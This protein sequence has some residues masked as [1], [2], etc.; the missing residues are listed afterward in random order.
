MNHLQRTPIVNSLGVATYVWKGIGG[1]SD[2]TDARISALG[3]K[4][5][6][7]QAHVSLQKECRYNGEVM[8]YGELLNKIEAVAVR[9][10]Y[11]YPNSTL[12]WSA[13]SQSGS[14]VEI[15]MEVAKAANLP[16]ITDPLDLANGEI[17]IT[18]RK[19]DKLDRGMATTYSAEKA[20]RKLREQKESLE[21]RANEIRVEQHLQ[22]LDAMSNEDFTAVLDGV[23]PV[24]PFLQAVY[25]SGD[26]DRIQEALATPRVRDHF[27]KEALENLMS[28]IFNRD[29]AKIAKA[30]WNR[31]QDNLIAEIQAQEVMY[32][33]PN[34]SR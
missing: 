30:E 32:P 4:P 15:P 12:T 34:R 21:K 13:M 3:F 1:S 33:N 18:Q 17:D 28:D 11:V 7:S 8:T 10:G 23:Y 2:R 24:A 5:V 26:H 19:I 25:E 20:V 14:E 6:D 9:Q 22:D 16:D 31:R 29:T 27:P